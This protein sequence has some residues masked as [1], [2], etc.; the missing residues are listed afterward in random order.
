MPAAALAHIYRNLRAAYGSDVVDPLVA[1][2]T[3]YPPGSFLELTDGS[4]GRVIRVSESDRM[5][6]TVCLFDDTVTPA[7]ADIVN[8]A[9]TRSIRVQR[10]LDP[11]ALEPDVVEFFGGHRWSGLTLSNPSLTA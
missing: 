1:A 3:V 8:L 10:V 7:E 6:P 9:S 5:R 11:Q 4:I 2:L